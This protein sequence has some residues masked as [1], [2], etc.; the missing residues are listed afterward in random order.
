MSTTTRSDAVPLNIWL[1]DEAETP[2][3]G[4]DV[5]RH[6]ADRVIETYSPPGGVIVDLAPGR[7]EVLAAAA[8][9]GRAAV[10]LH[11]PPGCA[12]RPEPPPL[13][14]VKGTADL[15]IVVPP[16]S[17]LRPPRAHPLS[18]TAAGVASRQAAPLLRTGGFLVLGSLGCTAAARL[19]P[20]SNAVSAA[21][22]AGLAYYQHVVALLVHE[23]DASPG[24][25]GSRGRRRLAHADLLVFVK[26]QP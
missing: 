3:S 13:D 21:G 18:A 20:V 17:H 12:R 26:E 2:T 23:L 8:K 16:A 11:L 24:A 22:Q 15:A 14:A 1:P 4:S 5:R 19:D 25:T 10:V 9:A 6:I 7:G